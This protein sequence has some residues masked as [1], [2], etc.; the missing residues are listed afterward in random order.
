MTGILFMRKKIQNNNPILVE[1]LRIDRGE[2]QNIDFHNGRMNRARRDLYFLSDSIDL[3]DIIVLVPGG[4]H[5]CRVIYSDRVHRIHYLPT[6]KQ[7]RKTFRFV[8]S[9]IDY[10][11]KY[12]DRRDIEKLFRTKGAS[13]DILIVQN[14]LLTDAS[15]SNIA[16]LYHDH[17]I[18][19]ATPLLEGTTRQR[20]LEAGMLRAGDITPGNA[21]KCKK[22]ALMNAMIDFEIIENPFFTR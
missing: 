7:I 13:D 15:S 11:Y 21:E 3:R 18:T 22:M 12:L 14:G 8:T 10:P 17:W 4:T 6:V 1:T 19:P 20:Y 5:R 2:I 9:D 16:F